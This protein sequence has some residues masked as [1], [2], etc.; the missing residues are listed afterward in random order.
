MEYCYICVSENELFCMF[1]DA[2]QADNNYYN[3]VTD[4]F[5]IS[6]WICYLLSRLYWLNVSSFEKQYNYTLIYNYVGYILC[7]FFF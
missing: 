4:L 5:L 7:N 2:F 6:C 3:K 1:R